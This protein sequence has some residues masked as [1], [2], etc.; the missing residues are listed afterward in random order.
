MNSMQINTLMQMLTPAQNMSVQTSLLEDASLTVDEDFADMLKEDIE[1]DD[2]DDK[3]VNEADGQ[4]SAQAELIALFGSIADF[5]PQAAQEMAKKLC[6]G[7]T[8]LLQQGRRDEAVNLLQQLS[9]AKTQKD[10][11]SLTDQLIANL[12]KTPTQTAEV[13]KTENALKLV[14]AVKSQVVNMSVSPLDVKVEEGFVT[15]IRVLN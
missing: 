15:W 1:E 11:Q 13:M 8:Q 14:D 2:D 9:Q 7:L 5:T 6:E 4:A 12:T 3:K 10:V